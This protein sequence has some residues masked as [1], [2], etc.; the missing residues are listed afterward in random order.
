MRSAFYNN[1]RKYWRTNFQIEASRLASKWLCSMRTLVMRP[2]VF[3]A[4]R[5]I[6]QLQT[7]FNHLIGTY[8]ISCVNW[9]VQFVLVTYDYVEPICNM[10]IHAK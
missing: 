5:M 7:S 3:K 8:I 6:A 9:K 10:Y 1:V 4:F 2:T